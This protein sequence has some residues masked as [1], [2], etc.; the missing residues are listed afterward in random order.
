MG[1]V[2]ALNWPRAGSSGWAGRMNGRFTVERAGGGVGIGS[3]GACSCG[4][5]SGAAGWGVVGCV[6]ANGSW[7]GA[8]VR[9]G[10]GSTGPSTGAAE[11]V[12]DFFTST[13]VSSSLAFVD[14]I[15]M[16]SE[17]QAAS[18]DRMALR[19]QLCVMIDL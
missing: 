9:A 14:S 5:T 6:G 19:F 16:A 4:A 1:S 10:G 18:P 15:Q 2:W 12:V 8:A 13:D 7:T 17:Q 3:E 11:G